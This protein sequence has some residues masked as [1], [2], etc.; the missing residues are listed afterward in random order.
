MGMVESLQP[1]QSTAE[2][3]EIFD[4]NN[5]DIFTLVPNI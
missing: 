2:L 5:I 4:T 3:Y 1:Y